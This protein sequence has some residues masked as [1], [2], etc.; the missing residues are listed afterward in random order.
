[1]PTFDVDKERINLFEI[2]DTLLFSHYFDNRDIFK[3]LSDWYVEER[4]R[5]EVPRDEHDEVEEILHEYYFDPVIIEDPTRFCV[6]I[7]QNSKYEDI[8]RNSVHHWNHGGRRYFIMKDQLEAE[9][10]VENG[11]EK[12]DPGH[13]EIHTERPSHA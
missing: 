7:N 13:I 4:Y 10:A 2:S 3:K 12:T 8:L 6:A 5:F 9:K 1:M 11:A